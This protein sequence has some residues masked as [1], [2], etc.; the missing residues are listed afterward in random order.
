M[1]TLARRALHHGTD[2][3]VV[4]VGAGLAG[5][6]C[7]LALRDRGLAVALV[8][9][10]GSVDER[11]LGWAYDLQPNGLLALD[12]LGL[13]DEVGALGWPHRRW[14]AARLGGERLSRWEYGELDH[15]QPYA[16][17]V[18]PHLLLTHLRR[19]V[20][21]ARHV[22]L[23]APAAVTRIRVEPGRH[24]LVLDTMAGRRVLRAPLLIGA[25][26]PRSSVRRAAGIS[27][28][29]RRYRG[30]WVEIIAP[31]PDGEIEDGHVFIGR[32]DFLG[33]VPT[34]TRELVTFHLTRS[35]N[36]AEYRVRFGTIA[37][38]RQRYI[39]IAP[40]LV[41]SLDSLTSWEQVTYAPAVRVR[42]QRWVADGIALAGDA[43]VAVNPITSQGACLALSAGVRLA[44]VVD[45]CFTRND[46]SA[47][48]LAPYEAWCRPEAEA[49]Q[50][51][52][53][54]CLWGFSS[55]NP[56]AS[57]LRE[58]MM[59][60]FDVD[61]RRRNYVL[62]FFSGMHQV[63]HDGLGWR[64]GLAAAGL[65]RRARGLTSSP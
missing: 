46:L 47:R 52:G 14:F 37:A 15:P 35:S 5:L 36:R 19:E 1:E 57:W 31:R 60:R 41:E 9:M 63:A 59:R 39:T 21:R 4:V 26:G 65:W 22:D 40:I 50:A 62:G 64:E 58:R 20:K 27:A 8:D 61:P 10:R 54:L 3:D 34:R 56:A 29:V 16:V 11:E 51:V 43:A 28:E 53:D 49:V 6:A 44:T 13:L 24:Q 33:V 42:A 17:C 55:R 45:G 30:G 48:G 25:D 7:V 12:S 18:R 23:I 2:Y 32:D 38:L